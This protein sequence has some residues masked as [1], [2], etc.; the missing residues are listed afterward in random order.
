MKKILL[1]FTLLIL[2]ISFNAQV[3][4]LNQ[5][6]YVVVSS[7]F[8]FL[9]Q[10]DQYQTSSLTKFLINKTGI[11]TYLDSDVLPG[12]Y[13]VEKCEGLYATVT[14]DSSMFTTKCSIVFN[15][16]YGQLVYATEFGKS[17]EKEFK[18]A[19]HEAIR[20][21]Y[22][23]IADYVYNYEKKEKTKELPTIGEGF[24]KKNTQNE[25]EEK[26]DVTLEKLYAQ[27][28]DNGYQ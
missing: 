8:N 21:A 17:R 13:S 24:V 16:C 26:P 9:K 23:F 15:N 14:E 5:Y 3:E 7:N 1:L 12:E 2:S 28:K 27:A 4:K 6:K 11:P 19:Y 20:N 18:K 25:K 10:A 22:G